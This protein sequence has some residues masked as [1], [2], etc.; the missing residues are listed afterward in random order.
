MAQERKTPPSPSPTNAAQAGERLVFPNKLPDD[1]EDVSWAL[2]TAEAM[3]NRGDY[4]EAVRW[5]RRAAEAASESDADARHLELAKAAAELSSQLDVSARPTTLAPPPVAKTSKTSTPPSISKRAPPSP[6][7][8]PLPLKLKTEAMPTPEGDLQ[9]SG[10]RP[11]TRN[12]RAFAISTDLETTAEITVLPI[13]AQPQRLHELHELHE[14]RAG[15]DDDEPPP[16]VVPDKLKLLLAHANQSDAWPMRTFVDDTADGTDDM[17]E[18]Q[19]Q[20]GSSNHVG[21]PVAAS[22][23][24]PAPRTEPAVRPS[25]A[26]RVV[27][28]RDQ[29]RVRVAP[30]GTKV[31]AIAVEAVLVALDPSADLA[32]WLTSK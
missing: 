14:S 18:E 7:K 24:P 25:Q 6:S 28:W 26:V 21:K 10:S 15:V 12:L 29:D 32:A 2:S 4:A 31:S 3:W 23:S 8:V 27:V 1:A 11:T 19:T 20:I 13:E 17:A 5:I 9:A 22:S 16:T 30:L